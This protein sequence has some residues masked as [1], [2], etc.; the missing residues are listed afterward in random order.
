M[1]SPSI[2]H[3][4]NLSGHQGLPGS[5]WTVEQDTLTKTISNNP[6]VNSDAN[7]DQKKRLLHD[8]IKYYEESIAPGVESVWNNEI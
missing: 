2:Q 1:D 7:E 8:W 4:A 6:F 5:R 3:L